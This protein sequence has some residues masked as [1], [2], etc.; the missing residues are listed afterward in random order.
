MGTCERKAELLYVQFMFLV[1]L[2]ICQLGNS[3]TVVMGQI[4]LKLS[5][6]VTF[7]FRNFSGYMQDSE[8]KMFYHSANV[9]FPLDLTL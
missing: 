8:E 2:F 5:G 3:H 9:D 6:A 7:P 1:Y 4:L